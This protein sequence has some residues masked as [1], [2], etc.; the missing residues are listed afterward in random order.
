[1]LNVL[2]E[3]INSF[4]A[5]T[6]LVIIVLFTEVLFS[7]NCSTVRFLL[8]TDLLIQ[9]FYYNKLFYFIILH[10]YFSIQSNS[11]ILHYF[12]MIYFVVL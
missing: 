11:S 2:F 8:F 1:M 7:I 4:L 3:S 9:I 5:S 6:A 12:L 10:L